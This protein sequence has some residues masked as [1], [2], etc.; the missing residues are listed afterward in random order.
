MFLEIRRL[1][2]WPPNRTIVAE[3]QHLDE[4]IFYTKHP[5]TYSG[6][7]ISVRLNQIDS[8]L[9]TGGFRQEIMRLSSFV[10][11]ISCFLFIGFIPAGT[12]KA[13]EAPLFTE[14]FPPQE[15]ADR[16]TKVFDAIGSDA[17]ALIQGEPSAR[18]YTRFRQSN[19]FYYLS[20]IEVP[21]AYLLLNGATRRTTL[22]LEHRKPGRERGE[23]KMLS[24]EDAELVHELSGIDRV[25]PLEN[26]SADLGNL[27]RRGTV[28]SLYTLFQP[29]EGF[30]ESRDLGIRRTTDRLADPW[31]G[32]PSREA[33]FIGLLRERIPG[34][35]VTNL[36][37]ILDDLR[38]FK[39]PREMDM[40]RKATRLAGLAIMEAMR[41][42]EPGVVEREI[43]A[44]AKFIYYRHGAQGDA[45]YS[46]IA[47]GPNA[48]FPHYHQGARTMKGGELLLFDYAPDVGYYMSDVTRMIPIS[49]QF[50]P[51]HRELYGFYVR[52][53]RAILDRIRPGVTA[54]EIKKEAAAEMRKTF[55][56]WTFS[57]DLHEAGALRF[58]ESYEASSNR[59]GSGRLGHGVGMATHDVGSFDGPLRAG[60]VFTI[61]P[62]LRV[63]EENL[64]IRMEDL[65][66]IHK[67]Y[68]EIVSDF[69]PM[70]IG[71]IEALMEEPGILQKYPELDVISEM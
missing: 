19:E 53:Y 26:L 24:A 28:S 61:E 42:V 33:H 21:H 37:P 68:A 14:D 54:N 41:S 67:D 58:V 36:N 40:I 31:D 45:Y 39:S 25:S 8:N 47:S 46:L 7:A 66:I 13:Q 55:E 44:L 43:D 62:A 18:G 9:T 34:M 71:D 17:V 32:R 57:N 5:R 63:P 20:G 15:F 10:T 70:E 27:Q 69:V 6:V 16:R 30:A 56:N 59:P 22:Y 29:A 49:G 12:I 3:I 60:M 35:T 4:Q 65:I 52:A 51:E 2:L 64:Y 38:F 23:G 50:S 48:P 11:L 1:L